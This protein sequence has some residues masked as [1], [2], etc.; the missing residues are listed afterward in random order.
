M[1]NSL[2]DWRGVEAEKDGA[3]VALLLATCVRPIF[4]RTCNG[5]APAALRAADNGER[6]GEVGFVRHAEPFTTNKGAEKQFEPGDFQM[7]NCLA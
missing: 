7:T 2:I 1:G 5:I 3:K 4:L 6:S